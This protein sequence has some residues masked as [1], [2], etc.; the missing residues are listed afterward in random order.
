MN[1]QKENT[2]YGFK[3]PGQSRF[4]IIAPHAAG[5]D[6][7]TG[8]IAKKLADSLNGWL[9][10]NNRYYKKS[11]R[12]ATRYPEFA[13]DFNRLSWSK[14]KNKYLWARKKPAMKKFYQDISYFCDQIE[15][16]LNCQAAVI[17]LHGIKD[18]KIGI[19]LGAGIKLIKE[20]NHFLRSKY[21]ADNNSGLTTLKIG[22]IKKIK[23]LL[24][25][26]LKKEYNLN[27]SVGKKHTGWSKLSAIQFHKHQGRDDFAL[28]IE[29]N[30][31]LRQKPNRTQLIDLL[32]NSL[33]EI[34]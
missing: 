13:E 31:F 29:I 4:V 3:R 5:D 19:D 15:T 7:K 9:I 18:K 34:F 17:Y 26:N 6:L 32:S 22:Q 25:N 2:T 8:L 30:F 24:Q 14:K 23:K 12:R 1:Y 10:V 16:A 20:S 27:V 21:S 33:K 11:N 28:Q